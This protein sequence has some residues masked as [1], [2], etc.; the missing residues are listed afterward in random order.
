M[1]EDMIWERASVPPS[2]ACHLLR[3]VRKDVISKVLPWVFW[4]LLAKIS[5][6]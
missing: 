5:E 6:G 4:P 1:R 2:P 3:L